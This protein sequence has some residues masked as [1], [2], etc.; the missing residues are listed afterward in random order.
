MRAIDANTLAALSGSRSGDELV[1]RV[2]YNG[3]LAHPDPLPI[4]SW[5][6]DWDG[7]DRQ[8]VQGSFKLNVKDPDGTLGPWLFDDP[9]GVGGSRIQVFYKVGGA[10][11]ISVGWYR[12][13]ENDVEE[14]WTFRIIQEDGY[15]EPDSSIPNHS[16]QIS[17]AMGTAVSVNGEELTTEIDSDEFLAPEQPSG[18]AP[19]V[20]G[21]VQRLVGDT[22]PLVWTGVTDATVSAASVWEENRMEAVMDLLALAGARHRMTGDGELEC[23]VKNPTPVFT[24]APG[25][26]GAVLINVSRSQSIRDVYNVGVVTSSREETAADGTKVEVPITGFYE[27]PSGPLR[28]NGPFGRRVIRNGNPLMDSQS[29]ADAAAR[30]LVLNRLAAQSIDLE[31]MCLPNPAI[32][33]GDYGTVISPVVDGRQVPLVGEVVKV[34]LSGSDGKVNAMQL[35]IRCLASDAASALKGYSIAG[36]ITNLVPAIT[37]DSLNP[38]RTWDQMATT[39]DD[40]EG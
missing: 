33:I 38:L 18:A 19:T 6:L 23:Y 24:C 20:M 2:W 11:E 31:V 39:F 12:I 15:V 30:S 32:Q 27:I 34:R 28:A 14:S 35:T 5:S 40:M 22:V 7:D 25:R 4:S 29:K 26:D 8:K 3:R 21:E 37:W 13:T 9:L 1:C 17:V 16:R 10:G 36:R